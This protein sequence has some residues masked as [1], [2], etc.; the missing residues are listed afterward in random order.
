MEILY[1]AGGGLVV[2]FHHLFPV[3]LV[4]V[5]AGL[6]GGGGSATFLWRLYGEV[7][8]TAKIVENPLNL[9]KSKRSRISFK[10]G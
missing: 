6:A 3:A 5:V 8:E 10:A 9:T 4:D 7:V 2:V 1:G